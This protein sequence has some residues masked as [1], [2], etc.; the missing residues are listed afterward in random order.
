MKAYILTILT[1]TAK[2]TFGIQVIELKE[3]SYHTIVRAYGDNIFSNKAATYFNVKDKFSLDLIPEVRAEE[4]DQTQDD[5]VQ[6]IQ[7][8]PT[9]E[10]AKKE[11]QPYILAAIFAI[12][13]FLE[14]SRRKQ[15]D[16]MV[17]QKLN[18]FK[19]ISN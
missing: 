17:I 13:W 19:K 18:K 5:N 8:C 1:K 3:D 7:A 15:W 4:N 14:M 9:S 16:L 11:W 2:I 6:G 12:L 10:E